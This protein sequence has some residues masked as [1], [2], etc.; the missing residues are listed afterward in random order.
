MTR[1][2]LVILFFFNVSGYSQV[3]DIVEV[4]NLYEKAPSSRCSSDSLALM[5]EHCYHDDVLKGYMGVSQ[6]ILAKHVFNP[7]KK[8][9]LFF[10]G[11]DLLEKAI[12]EHSENVELRFLRFCVQSSAPTFLG[13]YNSIKEDKTL[14]MHRYQTLDDFDLIHRITSYFNYN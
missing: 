11:R 7:F 4:R 14:I 13:Y 6:M 12:L 1:N 8:S 3:C 5:L 2:I 10:S 9:R